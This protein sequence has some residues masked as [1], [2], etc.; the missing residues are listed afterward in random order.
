M[1]L[2]FVAM[3]EVNDTINGFAIAFEVFF[4]T[5][6]KSLEIFIAITEGCSKELT[7]IT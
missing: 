6:M 3:E 1:P 2:S 7:A 4:E 5:D